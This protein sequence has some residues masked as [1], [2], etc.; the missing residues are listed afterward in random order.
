[1]LNANDRSHILHKKTNKR[2]LSLNP[3]KA[4]RRTKNILLAWHAGTNGMES[5]AAGSDTQ[6]AT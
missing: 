3:L 4:L 5:L 2:T 6:K 1:M